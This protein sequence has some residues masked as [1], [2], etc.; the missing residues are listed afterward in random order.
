[1]YFNIA[2]KDTKITVN[3]KALII[4]FVLG[5]SAALAS[6]YLYFNSPFEKSVFPPCIFRSVLKLYCPGCGGTR[7]TYELLHGNVLKAFRYNSL[8]ILSIPFIIYLVL[9]ILD[10]NV[11]GKPLLPKLNMSKSAVIALF[12]II[13]GYWILRNIN[14]FPFT[15]LAP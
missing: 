7:A 8:Y 9:L 1:M 13:F 5:F 12:I 6:I 2:R 14:I 11:N 4:I 3:I 10:I 15:L